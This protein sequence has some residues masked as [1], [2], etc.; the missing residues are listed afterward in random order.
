MGRRVIVAIDA[1]GGD[2]APEAIVAGAL[3]CVSEAGVD[4]CLYGNS[5]AIQALL[6]NGVAPFGVTVCA[7]TQVIAM[8][9]DAAKSVR[10]Q[11]DSS[12][13]RAAEAVRD[14]TAD[15]FVGA[16]N[17]GATM[18]AALLRF[19]R[20]KGVARPAIAVPLPIPGS[21]RRCGTVAR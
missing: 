17:T 14:R 15:A 3:R 16:G 21:D 19:G 11:R 18:A 6:P 7:T 1:M 12:I 4:V 13:V 5:D 9:A 20:I 8:D 2:R 10:A